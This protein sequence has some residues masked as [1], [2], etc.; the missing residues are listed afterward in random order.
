VS[1]AGR[2]HLPYSH[3]GVYD[4]RTRRD[5]RPVEDLGFYDP[6]SEKEPVRINLDRVKHWLSVGARP[7]VTVATILKG[8]GM[9]SSEWSVKKTVSAAAKTKKT[10][11]K[12]A[13]AKKAAAKRPAKKADAAAPAKKRKPRTVSSKKRGEKAA[14]K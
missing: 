8:Q 14:A 9:S 4:S 10:A 3:S 2:V 7:S 6:K 13:S 1:R 5:G 11:A 12:K